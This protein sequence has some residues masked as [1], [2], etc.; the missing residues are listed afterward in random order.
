VKVRFAHSADP[1]DAFMFHALGTGAIATP[2]LEVELVVDEIEPLNRSA[3]AGEFEATAVSAAAYLMIADRYRLLDSGAAMGQGGG[4]IVAGREPL[5]PK[6]IT[7][8]V[9]AIPGS[10]T[11]ASLLLRLYC[12]D[13]A[14]IEVAFERIPDVVRH[15]QAD[16]GLLIHEGQLT[17]ASLGL[18]KVFDLG[19]AWR[20]DTG[21][22]L[23]LGVN[24]ARRDLGED[25]ARQLSRALRDS[26]AWARA[27]RTEAMDGAMRYARGMDRPTCERFVDLFVNEHADTLGETGRAALTRLFGA[28]RG[29]GLVETAPAVDPV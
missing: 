29:R 22:P 25:V 13:P 15:A 11:T 8:R 17:H 2:G 26:I 14:M 28:A 27:H 18:V 21:L 6:E 3:R 9:V 5:D 1:D 12:G 23:P 19:E 24:V 4:P 20:R 16:L 10:H 7:D